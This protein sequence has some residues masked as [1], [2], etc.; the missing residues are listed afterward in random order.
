MP[1]WVP[2]E[3][4]KGEDAYIIGGGDSLR[5]QNFN[6]ELLRGKNTIG[7]NSALILGS[8][9]C[10]IMLF[11]DIRWW[12][13]LGRDEAE[14]YGGMVVG[15]NPKLKDDQTPWL[16]TMERHGRAREFG[17]EF[18]AWGDNT[19]CLAVNLAL[20]LGAQRVFLLGFDMQLGPTGRANWHTLRYEKN[21]PAVY[22]KFIA[23]FKDMAKSL[24]KV[25]PG[26]EVINVNDDS[27]LVC[28]PQVSLEEH[29]GKV[30]VKHG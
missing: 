21:T 22:P 13:Q 25:F 3:K 5:F 8:G 18:P 1:K 4:W 15:C 14:K 10:K 6:W 19:G 11:G 17:T 16:L 30:M 24:P 9:I 29:F 12:H 28:F 27:K 20:I 23:H 2:G 26:R 7:C